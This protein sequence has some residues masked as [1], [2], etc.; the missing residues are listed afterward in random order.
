[1]VDIY[2]KRR[3][4]LYYIAYTLWMIYAVLNITMW[5][6]IE[7]INIICQYLR[8]IAY[9]LLVIRFFYKQDYTRKDI[10]GIFLIIFSCFLA[11]HSVYNK[12]IIP[13]AIFVCFVGD[14]EFE[15]VLRLTLLI[16]T[17]IMLVTIMA[18]QMGIIEDVIWYEG[19]RVR[20]SL[21]YE[22]CGYPAHL[23]FFMTMMWF[24]IR[25]K[26]NLIE[27]ICFFVVNYMMY[28]ATDS[29]TDF[30]LAVLFLLG[31]KVWSKQYC[32][33]IIN[34]IRNFFIKY[35]YAFIAIL[36]IVLHI[37][38]TPN[39]GWMEKLNHIL[40]NRLHL[41]KEAI[42]QYG[43][44]LL[45]KP[46]RWFGQGSIKADPTRIYNYVDC[47]FLKEALSYGVLL[48]LLLMTGYYFL[49]KRIIE[50]N[51]H[52]LGWA[53]LMS[54]V[55]SVINAHLCVLTFNVFILALGILFSSNGTKSYSFSGSLAKTIPIKFKYY[56]K[57]IL[58]RL[59]LI[60][61]FCYLTFVQ[62]KGT[63]FM[64]KYESMHR[65]IICGVI[66]FI[67]V[68]NA[69]YGRVVVDNKKTKKIFLLNVCMSFLILA[70]IS[71]FFVVKKFQYSAFC[72]IVFGGILLKSL[73]SMKKPDLVIS[74]FLIS[75]KIWFIVNAVL[76]IFLRPA[77]SGI[78]YSGLFTSPDYLGIVS[79]I[80]L[81]MFLDFNNKKYQL[82]HMI[83]V[84][85]SLYFAWMTQ[86]FW[87]VF[88][89]FIIIMFY[90]AFL[91]ILVIQKKGNI[92]Y[93][94][95]WKVVVGVI[96]GIAVVLMLRKLLYQRYFV[97]YSGL[98]FEKDVHEVISQT[99]PEVI[100]SGNW[101]EEV[102]RSL[103]LIKEY[104]LQVNIMGHNYLPE[105]AG[106]E[107]WAYNSIAMNFYRYG[108]VDGIAYMGMIVLYVIESIKVSLQKQNYQLLGIPAVGIL[109]AM[110]ET[111]E[112][113]FVHIGW[114][115]FWIG[116]I[117]IVLI[118]QEQ[119]DYFVLNESKMP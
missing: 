62:I 94:T 101:I 21:G 78:H 47:S 115:V 92:R 20:H 103:W 71:D 112:I 18:S 110:V 91:I 17:I 48:L 107:R 63:S 84:Y 76:C 6:D 58:N 105:I 102:K 23:L 65:W 39:I 118:K 70:A 114:M 46:I 81:V 5:G 26:V 45:G 119:N 97:L 9:L 1:M 15:K 53:E 31:G 3:E 117:W 69:E 87:I 44:S 79:L 30:L 38:Y 25:R 8:K 116:I 72:I 95:F 64:V 96:A 54:L 73:Q 7:F 66:L 82:F 14:V 99:I 106:K 57:R 12:Q 77:F 111:V 88:M 89:A 60:V 52:F 29:R 108:V 2:I 16:Q 80:A 113:P 27:A 59:I 42:I 28:R 36:S 61:T 90:F 35:G 98:T 19:E 85:I 32:N 34:D 33:G 83:G 68:L 51:E 93:C 37:A 67:A 74:D 100:R 11:S 4:R 40:N 13:V 43:F 24:C 50:K 22:Y 10:L 55:Y 109:I 75:Y 104:M 41:G 49:G 56:Q 86:K